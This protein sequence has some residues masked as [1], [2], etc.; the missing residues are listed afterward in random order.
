MIGSNRE[1][2]QRSYI[3]WLIPEMA[4]VVEVKPS[5]SSMCVAGPKHLGYLHLLGTIAGS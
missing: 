4:A 1:R 5:R 3:H 2:T